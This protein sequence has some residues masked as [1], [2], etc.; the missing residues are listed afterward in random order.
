MAMS[1]SKEIFLVLC[2]LMQNQNHINEI[3]FLN[4][5]TTECSILKCKC[6]GE[7]HLGVFHCCLPQKKVTQVVENASLIVAV[8][9]VSKNIFSEIETIDFLDIFGM[10]PPTVLAQ[11]QLVLVLT[12]LR[13]WVQ[14]YQWSEITTKRMVSLLKLGRLLILLLLMTQYE[15]CANFCFL[16]FQAWKKK[17]QCSR[18]SLNAL[19]LTQESLQ[20][21]SARWK[22]LAWISNLERLLHLA[23]ILD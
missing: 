12:S 16:Y 1:P 19:K 10:I 4:L 14:A 23:S 18:I 20:K 21:V 22:L 7:S 3:G 11:K 5:A 2:N 17:T 15:K 9:P 13:D 6:S 8:D